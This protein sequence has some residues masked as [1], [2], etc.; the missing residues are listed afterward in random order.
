[1]YRQFAWRRKVQA[2]QRVPARFVVRRG[3]AADFAVSEPTGADS[4]VTSGAG[5]RSFE[6]DQA[7][8]NR[9]T[10]SRGGRAGEGRDDEPT[11][12][13]PVALEIGYAIV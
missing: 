12:Y 1:M 13:R 6:S 8:S 11:Q 10:G 9:A 3:V 2:I 4:T 7:G 5:E